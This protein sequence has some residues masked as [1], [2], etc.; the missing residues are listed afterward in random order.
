MVKAEKPN[1]GS[2]EL[3][4]PRIVSGIRGIPASKKGE[5]PIKVTL[6]LP[7]SLFKDPQFTAA[8]SVSDDSV[9]PGT[10]DAEVINNITDLV[11][12]ATGLEITID[13][14]PPEVEQG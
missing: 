11:R 10:V 6:S 3:K 2:L 4:C 9:T 13:Q 7:E 14:V 12:D 1:F 8:I 5:I